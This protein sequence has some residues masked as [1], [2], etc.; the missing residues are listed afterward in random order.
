MKRWKIV[1]LGG[2]VLGIAYVIWKTQ[3]AHAGDLPPF[4]TDQW[5]NP[6]GSDYDRWGRPHPPRPVGFGEE[7]VALTAQQAAL[8]LIGEEQDDL[9]VPSVAGGLRIASNGLLL[10]SRMRLCGKLQYPLKAKDTRLSVANRPDGL[11]RWSKDSYYRIEVEG[12]PILVRCLGKL[13]GLRGM[14]MDILERPLMS[15]WRDARAESW[16]TP[17]LDAEGDDLWIQYTSV[18]NPTY[19]RQGFLE[20]VRESAWIDGLGLLPGGDTIWVNEIRHN[21]QHSSYDELGDHRVW[22]AR[23]GECRAMTDDEIERWN[24][25]M[26]RNA[27]I[28]EASLGGVMAERE[29]AAQ[30]YFGVTWADLQRF[31]TYHNR[32][33][34]PGF[35]EIEA[36]NQAILE[37]TELTQVADLRSYAPD[38]AQGGSREVPFGVAPE[39]VAVRR[40]RGK[41]RY[42]ALNLLMRRE[43]HR[44]WYAAYRGNR[45]AG[46]GR[47]GLIAMGGVFGLAAIWGE[48]RQPTVTIAPRTPVAISQVRRIK[49]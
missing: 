5:G 2:G 42:D 35:D 34:A 45:R 31:N 19:G 8:Y 39:D 10:D 24:Q 43:F 12:E 33:D 4:P 36:R 15:N 20:V 48:P 16:R 38:L 22:D 11:A 30:T 46:L 13:A 1:V 47:N 25:W 40:R 26:E 14:T 17:Q 41:E 18:P 6:E 3:Q 29:E 37:R 28:R 23:L 7:G 44:D 27:Q 49:T 21:C 32:P 9:T